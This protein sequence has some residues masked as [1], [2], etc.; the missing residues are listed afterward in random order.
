MEKSNEEP[1]DSLMEYFEPEAYAEE[2]QADMKKGKKTD[3][4]SDV[5]WTILPARKYMAPGGQKMQQKVSTAVSTR[6]DV[7]NLQMKLDERLQ[8]RQARE[9]GIC[10]VREEL[11]AQ[12]FD[13]IIR[14]ITIEQP[15]RGLLLL[16]VRDEVRMTIAAY[17]TLYASSITFGMRKTMQAESGNSDLVEKLAELEKEKARLHAL[18]QDQRG[19]YEAIEKRIAEQRAIDEKQ[20]TEEREFLKFQGT[21]LEKFIADNNSS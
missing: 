15:S 17:Q 9:N 19:L 1:R 6:E 12:C 7:I 14:Q 13:E 2:K 16:R 4:L 5:L 3:Q 18:L 8:E 21:H 11:Y 10:P 20:R